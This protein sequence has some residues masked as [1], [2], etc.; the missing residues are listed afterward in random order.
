[1]GVYHAR[2]TAAAEI[3]NSIVSGNYKTDGT[4]PDDVYNNG[5]GGSVRQ[6]AHSLVTGSGGSGAWDESDGVDGGGNVDA[7]ADFLSVNRAA[8]DYLMLGA[9]SPA[10]DGGS[11]E[12]YENGGR[13][14]ALDLDAASNPRLYGSS[15]DMGAFERQ[16]PAA[17]RVVVPTA[18]T[19]RIG[20]PLTF[21]VTFDAPVS[22]AGTPYIPLLVGGHDRQARYESGS[23]PNTMTFQYEVAEGDED[24]EG[25]AMTPA[26]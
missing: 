25:I 11:D 26:I 19:Y 4:T 16:M 2:A 18:G 15:I 17:N 12:G 6:Y 7:V 21:V 22:V 10:I 23:E 20:Q 24:T 13:Q 5:S 3:E 14:L 8:T 1:G 9:C